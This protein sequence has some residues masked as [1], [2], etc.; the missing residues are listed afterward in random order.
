M[1]K[2]IKKIAV[3][4][5]GVMGAAIA[6]H[7]A[8]AGF[9]VLLLDIVPDGAEDRNI[10]AKGAIAK[11]LKTKPAPFTHKSKSKL[12]TPGNLE[13]DL[14]LL[15][16]VDWVIEAI[17]ENLEIKRKLYRKINGYRKEGCVVSSNTSTIPLHDLIEGMPNEFRRDF[18]ITHFFNPPR[19]M[20]LLELVGGEETRQKWLDKIR[21][22]CDV[23][24]GKGVV[25]CKDSPGFI[26]NR[27]GCFWMTAGL[28]EAVSQGVSVEVADAVMGRPVGIPKTGVFGLMDLI[29]ID[30]LPLI[31]KEMKS[32][33]P[34]KDMFCKIYDMPKTVQKMIDDGY[35][36]RKGK[37]GFYRLNDAG[38]KKV[39][40]SVNLKNGEYSKS[41][42][43]KLD[44]VN[45][46]KGGLRKLVT[47]EDEGGKY[48]WEVL[49][50]TL[51]YSAS[52]V[53]EISDSIA[54]VDEAMRLGY[55]WKYGPFELIDRLGEG[56]D[57][58]AAWFANRLKED[59]KKVPKI[60]KEIGDKTFYRNEND[61][62]E[63]LDI[64]TMEYVPIKPQEGAY[65]LA[66]FK[67]GKK[68]IKK[69][70]SSALW[71]IGD[72]VVCLEFTSKMNS[73]DPTILEMMVDAVEIVK[74]DYKALVIAND[75]DN[76]SVG[77][78]IGILLFAANIAGWKM[79]DGIIKQGQE[80]V[81]ALK[82]APFPVV[83]AP[84]GMALGGGCETL[85]H[86]DAIQA[87][88][89]TYTG[90]VEV[91]VGL[92][93][94]WGGCKEMLYRHL[95]ASRKNQS[96]IQ[97]LGGMFSF[98]P[99]LKAMSLMPAVGK[100]FE[101]ISTAKVAESA[102]HAKRMLIFPPGKTGITMNR[103][104]LLA[105]AKARALEM[106]KDYTP[107]EPF[108]I[109]LPGKT[110]RAAMNMAVNS[111]VKSGKAT[112]HDEVVSK[113]LARVLSGG[114]TDVTK[115]LTEQDI[116]DL[117]K[118]IFMELVRHPDSMAR[119]EH[120]LETGKPLRN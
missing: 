67:R 109:T 34:A 43:P 52:L 42:K 56:K 31:A 79:I 12:V 4:G 66:D 26:A 92:V 60:L 41:S 36:G 69:N 18:M 101:F 6:A 120:M 40:E 55:N 47:H 64:K 27:I 39:K 57:T 82:Y 21:T 8:N 97:K 106:A 108:T 65:M 29:G 20:K 94:G 32:T 96:K 28:N 114:K 16:E 30:L 61:T 46:A 48:A 80:A 45:A 76:F 9:P 118:E 5:S 72:G 95:E 44:S 102:E 7:V 25:D 62:P 113:A 15:G 98:I 58:G 54:D 103:K 88:V 91:G 14:H 22:F 87:H 59:G 112:K 83:G 38:G 81:M 70:G 111:F 110:G 104:R 63:Y 19:Y 13:D 73:L 23:N 84:T 50:Q 89:E 107:P 71:D 37:G 49:A 93:P 3:V 17:I 35:T 51:S 33:L 75:G 10:L 53:P 117:E 86:C 78:N 77:A 11:L 2:E 119:I 74:K 100:V 24:L 68:P 105:D 90:L 85:L 116:L 1:S 115:E 99:Q